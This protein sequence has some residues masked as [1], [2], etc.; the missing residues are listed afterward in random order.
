MGKQR[1]A[2]ERGSSAGQKRDRKALRLFRLREK[3]EDPRTAVGLN[4][5][6]FFLRAV[7]DG[8]AV[9]IFIVHRLA[10]HKDHVVMGFISLDMVK[11]NVPGIESAIPGEWHLLPVIE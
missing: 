3:H 10:I 6:L 9:A 5:E 11:R 7:W 8:K 4:L 1:D 2:P